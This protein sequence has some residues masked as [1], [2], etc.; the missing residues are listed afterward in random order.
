MSAL[1]RFLRSSRKKPAVLSVVVIVFVLL[2]GSIGY[3]SVLDANARMASDKTTSKVP[4]IKERKDLDRAVQTIDSVSLD[5]E[6]SEL[7]SV[8][9]F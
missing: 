9:D 3:Y 7:E 5:D 2:A 4:E 6:L 1:D 8:A